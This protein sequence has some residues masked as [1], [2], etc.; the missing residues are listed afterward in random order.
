MDQVRTGNTL[1]VS[2]VGDKSERLSPFE[3]ICIAV[4]RSATAPGTVRLYSHKYGVTKVFPMDSTRYS[5]VLLDNSFL[6]R[7]RTE[8]VTRVP[9]RVLK[10]KLKRIYS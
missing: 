6:R 4:N 5:F 9:H 3:G 8:F 2:Y 1:T 10:R 7:K